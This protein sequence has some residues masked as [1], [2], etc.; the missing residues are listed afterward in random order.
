LTLV[1]RIF[2]L[3]IGAGLQ[4]LQHELRPN[5]AIFREWGADFC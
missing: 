1:K 4:H 5:T 2:D 3:C